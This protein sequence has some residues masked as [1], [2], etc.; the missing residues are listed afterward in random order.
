M[1]VGQMLV[2]GENILR[3]AIIH[4]SLA[5][6]G[7]AERQ[8]L[9]LA[10]ILQNH[11]HVVEVFVPYRSLKCY[12]E[13]QRK[14]KICSISGVGVGGRLHNFVSISGVWAMLRLSLRVGGGFD[15][16]N[17]HNSPS[18]WAGIFAKLLYGTPVVWMC[19]EHPSWHDV[20]CGGLMRRSYCLLLA[21]IDKLAVKLVDGI[22]VKMG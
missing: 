13:L 2:N 16:V 15:V 22:V 19:N 9:M 14:L 1:T 21:L 8:L 18:H 5:E 17:V 6:R 10:S 3:I 7:G 11:G 4:T 12:G 20:S